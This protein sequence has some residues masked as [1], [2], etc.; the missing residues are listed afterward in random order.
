MFKAVYNYLHKKFK[1][2]LDIF[3]EIERI[4]TR[5]YAP[6]E[7]LK[8]YF[9]N[10]YILKKQIIQSIIVI[11]LWF[12]PIKWLIELIVYQIFDYHGAAY[13]TSYYG[14]AFG[15][16]EISFTVFGI[17]M[18]FVGNSTHSFCKFNNFITKIP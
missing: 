9:D 18:F 7:T 8:D 5:Y 15:Q 14:M 6:C 4:I 1:K 13:Y 3:D 10:N 16:D 17:L 2:N 11:I 12:A